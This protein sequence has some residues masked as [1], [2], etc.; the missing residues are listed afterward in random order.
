MSH[1]SVFEY[2]VLNGQLMP[3]AEARISIFN[4]AYFASFGVY[5]TVKV[6]QGRPFYLEEHLRRL[7]QSAAMI[8]LNLEAGVETLAGWFWQLAQVEPQATWSLKIIALGGIEPGDG[9]IIGMQPTRLP[10]YPMAYY[11]TGAPA[12]LFEG[13][14]LLPTC[15]SLNTLVNYLA[16]R[17]A[18]RANVL[19]G[20]LHHAGYLTEGSRTNLFAVRSGVV[21]TPPTGE[22]L[23][24]ITRD[25]ILQVL[26]RAGQPV[27][28]AP[29]AVDLAGI[30][31]F[32]ISSTSM[33]V[34]PITT[35]DGRPIGSGQV[36]AVTQ[37]VMARF[38][39]YYRAYMESVT[40][41][42]SWAKPGRV[43]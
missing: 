32:F 34:M 17:K 41:P 9:A 33:H 8:D 2:A 27:V 35:I 12:I 26:A 5:E 14:R 22:V 28:E 24:G 40:P 1:P 36:G 23:S 38:E 4:P 15:K 20:L 16:R 3:L 43:V 30:D 7:L 21:Y 18:Q 39:A 37:Q 29:V 25:I 13:Q 11:Q 42:V 31:E 19:E 6:D 10:T